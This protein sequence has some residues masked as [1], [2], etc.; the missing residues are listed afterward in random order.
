MSSKPWYP[1]Y[2]SDYRAK[3]QHLDWMRDAAYRRLLDAYYQTGGPIVWCQDRQTIFRMVGAVTE[4]EQRCVIAVLCEFFDT[5]DRDFLVHK[6]ADEHLAKRDKFIADQSRRGTMGAKARWNGHDHGASIGAGNGIR[7]KPDDGQPHSH[8][9]SQRKPKSTVDAGASSPRPTLE[10][11]TAY[12]RE[13]GNNVD[14]QKWLDHYTANGWK[15]G[16][17]AMKDWRA[18]VRTWERNAV[19]GSVAVVAKPKV[20]SRC[21][22]TGSMVDSQGTWICVPCYQ[23]R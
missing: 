16:K 5:S 12:C 8:S 7:H 22:S 3:T 2:P 11:I 20:C 6:T 21:G 23:Q 19:S 10:E 13:R 14:P 15:V 17:N 4:E 18:A 1:W 9:H